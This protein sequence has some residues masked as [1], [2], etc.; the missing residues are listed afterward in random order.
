M[1]INNDGTV[2]KKAT[3][4]QGSLILPPDAPEKADTTFFTYSFNGWDGYA[5]GMTL[6]DNKVFTAACP[7]VSFHPIRRFRDH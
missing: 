5:S 1:F 2:L 4:E 6:T 3:A 7:K